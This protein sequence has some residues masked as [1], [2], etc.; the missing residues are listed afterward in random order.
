MFVDQCATN[1]LSA[2]GL[3][4]SGPLHVSWTPGDWPTLLSSSKVCRGTT[5]GNR[6]VVIGLFDHDGRVLE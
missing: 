4:L 2:V 1:R 5:P 3:L 6:E